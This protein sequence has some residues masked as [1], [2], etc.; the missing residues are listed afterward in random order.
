MI[1]LD[2]AFLE[3]KVWPKAMEFTSTKNTLFI[4]KL[5]LWTVSEVFWPSMRSVD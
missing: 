5:A 3:W 1:C 4:M 2:T